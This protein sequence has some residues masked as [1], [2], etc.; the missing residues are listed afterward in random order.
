ML[1]S[2][3][4]CSQ[5]KEDDYEIFRY[6]E[7]SAVSSLDPI[8]ARNQAMIWINTQLFD[9]L[10][11]LDSNLN[12]KPSLAHTWEVLDEST[13]YRFHLRTDVGFH[14]D[15]L[16]L[17]AA[18]VVFS[19]NRLINPKN[20]SPGKWI[21]DPVKKLQYINDSCVDIILH[22]PFP[23]FLSMLSMAYCSVI[24]KNIDAS[25][26]GKK[27]VGTGPFQLTAWHESN[28][29]VLRRN[30]NYFMKDEM[31]VQLP[32]LD[33]VAVSFVPDKQ[34]AFLNF[35]LGEI[36]FISG[37]DASYK[38]ELLSFEGDL[39]PKYTNK[40]KMLR[41]PYLNTEYLGFAFE[42]KPKNLDARQYKLLRQA[43][44]YG[45][46]RALMM[47][48]LRN[49]IGIPAERGMVPYG[50]PIGTANYGYSYQP[51]RV[52]QLLVQAGFPNG[53][54]L[55]KVKLL[56][57]ASY[58]DLCEYIQA[59]LAKLGISLEVEVLPP[60]TLREMMSTGKASMFRASWIADYPDAE[61]YLSLFKGSN[62]A[63]NGPNY[64][65]FYHPMYDAFYE[66]ALKAS[67]DSIRYQIYAKM[68]SLV[69]SQA[70][71]VPLYYDEAVR[72][73]LKE[74]EGLSPN[75]LNM[76]DLRKVRK[77]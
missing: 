47:K 35:L 60:S 18:D 39:R 13:R 27:P 45:F 63:P 16:Q 4:S 75:P 37:L 66:Q 1:I 51:D 32:Y 24:P 14:G 15:S 70:P 11:R 77:N 49:S 65:R 44:N 68:D 69:M 64:T 19:L 29:L 53:L 59:E 33:G 73:C 26:I 30:P 57:N 54:G 48:Y 55:T 46:D 56:T 3:L 61:N 71:V 17:T 7:V 36:D 62:K 2:L 67:S 22:Q 40:Y 34:A 28:K 76:L 31:G 42:N 58:L 72:F 43:I 41:G 12:V 20:A 23:A 5:A 10:V 74:W 8:Y 21:M 50:L 6:N 9:Q 25:K 38:D 52:K